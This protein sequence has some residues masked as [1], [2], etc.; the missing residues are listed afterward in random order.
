MGVALQLRDVRRIQSSHDGLSHTNAGLTRLRKGASLTPIASYQPGG[1]ADFGWAGPFRLTGY[2]LEGGLTG[3]GLAEL[4]TAVDLEGHQFVAKCARAQA[5]GSATEVWS[6]GRDRRVP[7]HLPASPNQCSDSGEWVPI[8][9]DSAE[10]EAVLLM[11]ASVLERDGGVLFPKSFGVWPHEPSGRPVLIMERLVGR[12]PNSAADVATVLEALAHA[13]LR[14]VLHRHG[15]LKLEHIFITEEGEPR[16]CD[17]APHF[18]G[19]KQVFTRAYNP[20]GMHGAAADVTACASLLRFLGPLGPPEPGAPDGLYWVS[21]VL[22]SIAPEWILDHRAA[23][24]ALRAE[25]ALSAVLVGRE[26]I[27]AVGGGGG[28]VEVWA[29]TEPDGVVRSWLSALKGRVVERIAPDQVFEEH[30]AG[31]VVRTDQGGWKGSSSLHVMPAEPDVLPFGARPSSL[32]TGT[33]NFIVLD[34]MSV[35]VGP[36]HEDSISASSHQ[37]FGRLRRRLR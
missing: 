25:P 22:D 33:T 30:P 21:Q 10:L 32:P 35:P 11:E 19:R 36:Q 23:A 12:R 37:R 1:M 9:L 4:Y 2:L 17:P 14:G 26:R 28:S 7:V 18:D 6:D 16:L 15:D 3:G 29:T 8:E 13:R 27:S 24:A 31:W 5:D 20:D 34:S